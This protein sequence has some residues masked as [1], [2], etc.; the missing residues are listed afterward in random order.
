MRRAGDRDEE[1]TNAVNGAGAQRWGRC[2]SKDSGRTPG[3]GWCS[4][5][6]TQEGGMVSCA[7]LS[8]VAAATKNRGTGGLLT[9][10][11]RRSRAWTTCKVKGSF[12]SHASCEGNTCLR[13]GERVVMALG[14]RV[15]GCAR[16]RSKALQQ[17]CS[18]SGLAW[19]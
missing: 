5:T 9:G 14:G 4:T 6:S 7:V 3:A 17:Q 1:L 19:G 2:C 8:T 13:E 12:Y 15:T 10:A 16:A 18:G 11:D